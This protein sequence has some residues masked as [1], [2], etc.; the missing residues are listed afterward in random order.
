MKKITTSGKKEA[1]IETRKFSWRQFVIPFGVFGLLSLLQSHIMGRFFGVETSPFSEHGFYL[2]TIA[3]FWAVISAVYIYL[4]N[5]QAMRNFG[6]PLQKLCDATQKVSEGDF[7]VHLTKDYPMKGHDYIGV[8]YENFNRMVKELSSIETLKN[9]FVADVSHEL[10]TPLSVIQNYGTALQD[11]ALTESERSEYA[12]TVVEA[13]QKLTTLI[14]NI[15]KLN[16]LE[17][18]ELA[19]E[20]KEY[21]LCRQLSELI[22]SFGS[23]FEEKNIDFEAQIEDSCLICSDEIMLSIVWQNILANAIKFTNPGGRITL[24]QKN[25]DN[26]IEVV[27]TDTGCGMSAETLR[28]IF[29]K[30]YQGDSSHS[31][32]G[33]GLGLALCN[34]VINLVG[35][36][37]DVKSEVGEGSVFIVRLKKK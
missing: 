31:A 27:I 28:H 19:P 35:G 12:K 13:A 36:E 20:L 24:I 15:L 26:G 17:N 22:L 2:I 7:S 32:E 10:K 14:T 21:D 6:V 18:Q 29:D 34:K 37:I 11:S 25:I 23:Q 30:F 4:Q 1:R 3:L 16:K 5:K 9:S 33:N 8:T